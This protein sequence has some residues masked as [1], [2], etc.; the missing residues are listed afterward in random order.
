MPDVAIVNQNVTATP[1]DYT[2][3]GAQE[4][5]VKAVRASLDGSGAASS[6]LPALQLLDPAGHVMWTAVNTS[7]PVAAGGS[8]DVSWFPGVKA[9]GGGSSSTG[10]AESAYL[11]TFTP[12][13]FTGTNT[14]AVQWTHFQTTD[15]SVFGTNAAFN[16]NTPTHNQAND[17]VL[18]LLSDGAYCLQTTLTW[19]AGTVNAY[20][21]I[22]NT[23]P[24]YAPIG[25]PNATNNLATV[26]APYTGNGDLL[27]QDTRLLTIPQGEAPAWFY[28]EAAGQTATNYTLTAATFLATWF[29]SGIGS[30]TLVY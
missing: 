17:F 16:A 15:S 7:S 6:F 23:N 14:Y 30:D 4:I 19:Q 20:A 18:V 13:T 21:G 5:F 11:T 22:Q 24:G 3:P 10:V 29:G 2:V 25:N 8:A 28:L 27:S 9:A 12:V 1:D 26:T